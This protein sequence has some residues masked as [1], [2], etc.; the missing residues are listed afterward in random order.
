[1]S[2]I[3][4]NNSYVVLQ[5]LRQLFDGSVKSL[6]FSQL[7]DATQGFDRRLVNHGTGAE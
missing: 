4:L 2:M 3:G 6:A 1:M 7:I 5:R